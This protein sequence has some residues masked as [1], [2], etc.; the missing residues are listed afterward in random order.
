MINYLEMLNR[1]FFFE[2]AKIT[3]FSGKFK[4]SQVDGLTAI[5]DEW[6]KNHA[7]KDDR[8]LAYMLATT[9]HETDR[10][11][12]GIEEYGKGKNQPYGQ[13]IKQDRTRYFDTANRFYGR[14]FVQLTWYEN[15]QRAGKKLGLDLINNPELVLEIKNATQILFSGMMEGWFT[16][17]KLSGYFNEQTED[18]RNARKIINRLDKADLIADYA[19]KYYAAISYTI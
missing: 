8:W 5:L 13:N 3:L 4:Q 19:K 2:Q 11:F 9:H 1:N 6:E 12:R 17:K 7:K 14:G 10:T 18:W 15:Y 16:G